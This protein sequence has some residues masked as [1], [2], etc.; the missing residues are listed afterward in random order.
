MTT[1]RADIVVLTAQALLDEFGLECARKLEDVAAQL[2]LQVKEVAAASFDGALLRVAGSPRGI[3]AIRR[4]IPEIGRKRFTLCHEIG[5]YVLPTQRREVATPCSSAMIESWSRSLI[6]L[7][8][9]ANRFA[10]EILIPRALLG[11]ELSRDPTLSIARNLADRFQTSLTA[12]TAR[13]VELSTYRTAMVMSQEGA[14]RWYRASDE[15]DRAVRIGTLDPRTLA[16]DLFCT[17]QRGGSATV[18]AD[19]WLFEENLRE[20]AMIEEHSVML[21]AYGSV[22]T[23]LEI[24]ERVEQRTDD[25]EGGHDDL[26]PT[27]FTL[28]RKH[29]PR[30]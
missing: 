4:D 6:S 12:A 13:L 23:L 14:A 28:Q 21:G 10:A 8:L 26:D 25:D 22:L 5:H 1:K 11:D 15:F 9:D 18:P 16:N 20:G 29:W 27:E 19:A 2:G 7:E 30:K 3:I 17:G 24:R